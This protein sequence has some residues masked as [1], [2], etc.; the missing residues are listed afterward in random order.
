MTD[1]NALKNVAA[2]YP[3]VFVERSEIYFSKKNSP[4]RIKLYPV[5]F[6]WFDG[7]VINL[8]WTEYKFVD[9][10]LS[11]LS[12]HFEFL[13]MF[14]NGEFPVRSEHWA[15]VCDIINDSILRSCVWNSLKS[16]EYELLISSKYRIESDGRIY[17][18]DLYPQLPI[19]CDKTRLQEYF[20]WMFSDKDGEEYFRDFIVSHN[21][22]CNGEGIWTEEKYASIGEDIADK[23]VHA[24]VKFDFSSGIDWSWILDECSEIHPRLGDSLDA[25]LHP[26]DAPN[27]GIVFSDELNLET[28]L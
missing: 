28:A 6:E 3:N 14:I 25:Y 23:F 24:L 12:K 2:I 8:D 20:G 11:E 4:K 21:S 10:Y 13:E 27:A 16:R 18:T 5:T 7:N 9:A 22:K 17:R 1:Q 26:A 15:K 19:I